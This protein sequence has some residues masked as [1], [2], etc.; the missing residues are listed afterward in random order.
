MAGDP[1]PACGQ[2]GRRVSART[3]EA[4]LD[5]APAA[6]M[7]FCRTASCAVV[8]F[9]AAA[10]VGVEAVRVPVFQKSADPDRL[11]CYCFGHTV[12]AVR[13]DTDPDGGSAIAE[14][15]TRRCRAGEDDCARTNPQGACCLG[16][17]RQV[18]RQT[19]PGEDDAGGC[20]GAG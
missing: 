1:C 9:G 5:D 6:P 17:V 13:D 2:R 10:T 11:V 19:G 7:W 18:A 16:N 4:M 14:A 3:L 15:I 20:C 12:R 8:Y